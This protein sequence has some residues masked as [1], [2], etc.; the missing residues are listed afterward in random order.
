MKGLVYHNMP[1]ITFGQIDIWTVFAQKRVSRGVS[2]YVYVNL[3]V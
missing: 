2:V 1:T 3:E